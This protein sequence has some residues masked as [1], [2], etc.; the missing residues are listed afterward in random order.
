VFDFTV[1]TAGL[2]TCDILFNYVSP[3]ASLTVIGV[4]LQVI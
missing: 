4:E 2:D 3:R 1:P